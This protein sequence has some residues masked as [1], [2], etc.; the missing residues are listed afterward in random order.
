M[1]DYENR[2]RLL[3]DSIIGLQTTIM[4]NTEPPHVLTAMNDYLK[5]LLDYKISLT[6]TVEV[7]VE[8]SNAV[9]ST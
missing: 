1:A 5:Q 9:T 3:T 4:L 6:E 2:T 8:G 7:I